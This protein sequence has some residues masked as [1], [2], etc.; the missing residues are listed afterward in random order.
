MIAMV[1]LR[2]PAAPPETGASRYSTPACDNE[3][4]TARAAAIPMVEVSITVCTRRSPAPASSSTTR[5]TA[6]PSGRLR[7]TAPAPRATSWLSAASRA[8]GGARSR[9]PA[10]SCTSRRWP[11]PA[12]LAA[13]GAPMLPRPMKPSVVSPM[14]GSCASLY[15]VVASSPACGERA[16]ARAGRGWDRRPRMNAS[17]CSTRSFPLDTWPTSRSGSP[18]PRFNRTHPP[19]MIPTAL[20]VTGFVESGIAFC[21][22]APHQ[23]RRSGRCRGN[24][25]LG[26]VPV[27][28]DLEEFASGYYGTNRRQSRPRQSASVMVRSL[29]AGPCRA[30]HRAPVP[31]PSDRGNWNR[32]TWRSGAARR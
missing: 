29:R 17:S 14:T 15:G 32:A 1:A 22:R 24:S 9:V 31:T 16:G 26:R 7:M 4:C 20:M 13:I 12:R 21:L 28:A 27:S 3:A 5:R 2:A 23:R 18:P 8:P 10:A 30:S 11:A 6:P 19:P 25:S